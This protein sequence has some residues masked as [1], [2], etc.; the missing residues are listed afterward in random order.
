MKFPILAGLVL[1]GFA[2]SAQADEA[3][4]VAA[5]SAETPAEKSVATGSQIRTDLAADTLTAV[6]T[7]MGADL[8]ARL[9][10]AVGNNTGARELPEKLLVSTH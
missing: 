7:R 6:T 4:T 1:A 8:E 3:D 9:E 10:R 2:W 5:A